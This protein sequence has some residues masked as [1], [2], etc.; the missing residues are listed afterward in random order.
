MIVEE[1]LLSGSPESAVL[2][3]MKPNISSTNRS[4]MQLS[5]QQ[6][7]E[8]DTW[9]VV[10]VRTSNNWLG[11]KRQLKEKQPLESNRT[12]LEHEMQN[13]S[14]HSASHIKKLLQSMSKSDRDVKYCQNHQQQR[15][16]K[17]MNLQQC[18]SLSQ[19]ALG[20]R[21]YKQHIATKQL[22]N[23]AA[24]VARTKSNYDST[25]K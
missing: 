25:Y 15:P 4:Q 24:V 12:E 3:K 10:P 17:Y 6:Q 22:P 20:K 2:Q 19:T 23:P 16:Q 9:R 5:Q 8:I 18:K 7:N 21:F 13:P 11:K 1:F 14:P